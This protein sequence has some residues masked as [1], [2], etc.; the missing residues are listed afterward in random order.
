LSAAS[1]HGIVVAVTF[2]VVTGLGVS[3]FDTVGRE[4]AIVIASIVVVIL[5]LIRKEI[6]PG[7]VVAIVIGSVIIQLFDLLIAFIGA[8]V[9]EVSMVQYHRTPDDNS[10][11]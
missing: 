6:E 4:I 11:A 7:A 3:N 2:L 5:V 10:V 1:T 9:T 8:F